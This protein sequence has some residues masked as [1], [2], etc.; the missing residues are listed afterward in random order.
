LRTHD[1]LSKSLFDSASRIGGGVSR[2]FDILLNL[3]IALTL[4]FLVKPGSCFLAEGAN[5]Q[6]HAGIMIGQVMVWRHSFKLRVLGCGQPEGAKIEQG[7]EL[8][9]EL[10]IID[11]TDLNLTGPGI[12]GGNIKNPGRDPFFIASEVA[13]ALA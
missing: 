11:P 3:H 5:D 1:W 13:I 7:G 12:A 6:L 4:V 8:G 2:F 9:N 10:F